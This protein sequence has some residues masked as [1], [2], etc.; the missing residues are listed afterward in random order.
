[1]NAIFFLPAPPALCSQVEL[2][3]VAATPWS[4]PWVARRSPLSGRQMSA[5]SRATCL[6]KRSVWPSQGR[7]RGA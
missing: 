4:Q 1:L 7:V 6:P 5:R 3:A 2:T